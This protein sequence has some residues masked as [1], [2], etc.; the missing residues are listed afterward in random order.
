MFLIICTCKILWMF[1]ANLIIT[2][3]PTAILNIDKQL[4]LFYTNN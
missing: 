1:L 3:R 2:F 4:D